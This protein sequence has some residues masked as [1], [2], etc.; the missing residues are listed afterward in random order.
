M[1]DIRVHSVS[2]LPSAEAR[3]C[4]RMGTMALKRTPREHPERPIIKMLLSA[5]ENDS[6]KDASVRWPEDTEENAVEVIATKAD[7]K[8]VAL[9][10]TLIPKSGALGPP[11]NAP[12]TVLTGFVRLL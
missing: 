6:W 5:Y 12:N 2:V 1:G 7:G 4:A 3:D 10:H 8:T 9:E 11:Q